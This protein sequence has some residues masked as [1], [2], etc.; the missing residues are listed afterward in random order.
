MEFC[1]IHF[2]FFYFLGCCCLDGP[3]KKGPADYILH[4][5]LVWYVVKL[6]FIYF[7]VSKFVNWLYF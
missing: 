1:L 3:P 5:G 2:S 6:Y 4:S 7:A